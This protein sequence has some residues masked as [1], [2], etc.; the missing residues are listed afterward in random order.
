[1]KLRMLKEKFKEWV[2]NYFGDVKAAKA[3]ILEEL[4]ILD[5]KEELASLSMEDE[6]RRFGLKEQFAS[7]VR[8]EEIK[9]KQQSRVRW[10]K[11]LDKNSKFFH[12]MASARQRYNKINSPMDGDTRLEDRESITTHIIDFFWS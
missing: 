3:K 6:D 12:S 5:L 4:Q 9:C 11:E 10:L 8:E 7:K 1:M 2:T